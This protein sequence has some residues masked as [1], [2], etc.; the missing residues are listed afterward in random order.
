[1]QAQN[2]PEALSKIHAGEQLPVGVGQKASGHKGVHIPRLVAQLQVGHG[3]A[4]LE[5]LLPGLG[6]QEHG[7][8][9]GLGGV[10]DVVEVLQGDV[11]EHADGDGVSHID[12]AADAPG[13]IDPLD[14]RG[15]EAQGGEHGLRGG[16]DGPLGPD[17]VVD[18]H[19]V[20]DH[21]FHA[22]GVLLPR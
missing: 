19:L 16:E 18:I 22:A 8:G 2:F 20:E 3:P 15:V 1:M 10:A 21:I 12:A 4:E 5:D 17:K 9:P 13:H 14:D 6:A 7:I 11:G